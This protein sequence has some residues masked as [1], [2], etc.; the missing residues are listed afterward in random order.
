MYRIFF[1]LLFFLS[2]AC[3]AAFQ[4]MTVSAQLGKSGQTFGASWGDFNGDGFPDLWVGNHADTPS[5][6][7][8][9]GDG[10]FDNIVNDVWPGNL[11]DTHGASWIDFTTMGIRTCSRWLVELAQIIYL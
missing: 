2:S 8:N 7:L 1:G 10:T 4:E 5:L 11:A 6:F 3:Q 9:K